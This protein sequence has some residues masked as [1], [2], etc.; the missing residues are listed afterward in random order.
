MAATKKPTQTPK[1]ISKKIKPKMPGM[2][3]TARVASTPKP[4][5]TPMPKFNDKQIQDMLTGKT[6]VTFNG[7][8]PK[9]SKELLEAIRQKTGRYPNTAR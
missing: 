1:P 7:K 2:G 4:K 6:P 5:A 3:P 8:K 9:N